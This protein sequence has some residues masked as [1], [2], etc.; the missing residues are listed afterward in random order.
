VAGTAK[1]GVEREEGLRELPGGVG[2]GTWIDSD[3]LL[4]SRGTG[5]ESMV[6][7]GNSCSLNTTSRNI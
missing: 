5:R 6:L 2:R 7:A 4:D 3:G 1:K